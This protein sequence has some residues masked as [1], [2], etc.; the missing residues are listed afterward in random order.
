MRRLYSHQN[1]LL[2]GYVKSVVEEH[3]IPC[4][5]KNEHLLGAAGELPPT[6][7]WPEVWVV[8]DRDYP[9]ALEIIQATMHAS[10]PAWFCPGCGEYL[11]GQFQMCWRCGR[12]RPKE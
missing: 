6:E 11:E 4:L 1:N 5:L 8:E 2:A 3:G 12:E 9:R 7:C 10:G